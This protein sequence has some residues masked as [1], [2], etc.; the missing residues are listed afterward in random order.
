MKKSTL[1]REL[2]AQRAAILPQAKQAWDAALCQAIITHP[3]FIS[4]REILGFFPI[5]T[6][7]DI[8]PVLEHALAQNKALYLPCCTPETRTMTFR[9]V[10]ALN[11]LVPGAHNIPEPLP[12]NCALRITHY[13]L[14]LVPGLAFDDRGYRLGYGGGY[15]DR[16]LA[17][18]QGRTLGICYAAMIGEIPTG[19][20]DLSVDVVVTEGEWYGQ[21]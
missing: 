14:C 11:E 2:L 17:N 12:T 13:A 10:D 16:F 18:F 8:K 15:Y 5:G 4:A 7:P 6:E 3:A 19:P 9:R 21:Q 1:R 20:H